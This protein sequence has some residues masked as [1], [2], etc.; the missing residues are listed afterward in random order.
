M[1]KGQ[2]RVQACVL[3]RLS[4][5]NACASTRP[6]ST[7]KADQCGH[8]KPINAVGS[9]ADQQAAEAIWSGHLIDVGSLT[10]GHVMLSAVELIAIWGR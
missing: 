5:R 8:S 9:G 10:T 7:A 4:S 1:K 6:P 3:T 2:A